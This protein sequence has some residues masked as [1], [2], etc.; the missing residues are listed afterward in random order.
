MFKGDGVGNKGDLRKEGYSHD[1]L[2]LWFII[3]ELGMS[4]FS[5]IPTP[6][7]LRQ[8]LS[9]SLDIVHYNL[10]FLFILFF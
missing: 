6:D 5:W 8:W 3:Q 10:E 7:K 2:I 9:G 4:Q 1:L